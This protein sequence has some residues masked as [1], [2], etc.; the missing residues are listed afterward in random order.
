[1]MRVNRLTDRYAG[2]FE[3]LRHFVGTVS[4]LVLGGD[5]SDRGVRIDLHLQITEK[6][7]LKL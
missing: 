5:R 4:A 3:S 2:L 7:T 1:M 6:V